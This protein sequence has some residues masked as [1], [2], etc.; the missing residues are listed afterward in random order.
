IELPVPPSEPGTPT[1]ISQLVYPTPTNPEP[2][3]PR[4]RATEA[5]KRPSTKVKLIGF[6]AASCLFPGTSIFG[7][8]FKLALIGFGTGAFS[9]LLHF[10]IPQMLGIDLE[11]TFIVKTA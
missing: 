9:L 5:A 2:Q 4:S 1:A 6:A 11:D 10:G 7:F 8:G 3:V